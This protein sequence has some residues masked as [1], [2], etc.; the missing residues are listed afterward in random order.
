[1]LEEKRSV[2]EKAEG[3]IY[4][5]VD[6]FWKA[7]VLCEGETF[8]GMIC[9]VSAGGVLMMLKDVYSLETDVILRTNRLGELAGTVSWR[10][11]E[12]VGIRFKIEPEEVV[13]MIPDILPPLSPS[14]SSLPK[15]EEL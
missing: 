7:T 3:R 10:S 4:T 13:A 15:I 2:V 8:S 1:M 14:S 11:S 6:V 12:S 5:R 9:N